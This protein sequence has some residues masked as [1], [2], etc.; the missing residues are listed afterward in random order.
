MVKGRKVRV[1]VSVTLPTG[2]V[3]DGRRQGFWD[4]QGLVPRRL[5]PTDDQ[6]RFW[7]VSFPDSAMTKKS[8]EENMNRLSTN[9]YTEISL[10]VLLSFLW[11]GSFTLIEVA[12][13]EIPPA[14]IVFGRLLIGSIF[15]LSIAMYLK[16][17]WPRFLRLWLLLALQGILQSALPFTLI[18]WGQKYIERACWITKYYS[19]SICIFNWLLHT[20]RSKGRATSICRPYYWANRRLRGHG[21]RYCVVK[22]GFNPWPT[23]NYRGLDLLCASCIECKAF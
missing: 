12:I 9:R 8:E 17:S 14:T 15:L 20:P 11:G 21:T 5:V 13:R 3:S 1:W 6:V 7:P 16:E 4:T 2:K 19:S 23:C 18:S 10:L 22:L